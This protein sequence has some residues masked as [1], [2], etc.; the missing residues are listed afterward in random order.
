MPRRRFERMGRE[1]SAKDQRR[2]LEFIELASRSVPTKGAGGVADD[3]DL[4]IEGPEGDGVGAAEWAGLPA[5]MGQRGRPSA[6]H[7]QI[8]RAAMFWSARG[9]SPPPCRGSSTASCA[10]MTRSTASAGNRMVRGLVMAQAPNSQARARHAARTLALAP[11]K[12]V[13][14]GRFWSQPSSDSRGRQHHLR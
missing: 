14:Q 3:D 1:R 7:C 6:R 11:G 5:D 12:V 8:V 9:T 2:R 10:S 4:A 13:K